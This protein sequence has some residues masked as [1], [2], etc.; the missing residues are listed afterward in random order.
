MPTSSIRPAWFG[1]PDGR[2]GLPGNQRYAMGMHGY[3]RPR[4]VTGKLSLAGALESGGY[5]ILRRDTLFCRLVML[6]CARAGRGRI[7]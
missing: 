7:C 6:G 1:P 3:P 2:A 5:P 4:C